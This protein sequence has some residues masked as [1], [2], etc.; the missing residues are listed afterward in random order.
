VRPHASSDP[1][2]WPDQL[3][4]VRHGESIG[5]L[6]DRRDQPTAVLSSPYRRA[7][8]TAA[9]ALKRRGADLLEHLHEPDAAER[10][11]HDG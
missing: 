4:L 3:V 10:N 11:R 6:A 7:A 9:L 2:T 8:G 1:P 5:N